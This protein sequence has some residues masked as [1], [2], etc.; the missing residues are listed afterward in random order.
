MTLLTGKHNTAYGL[1]SSSCGALFS[2]KLKI[3]DF[4]I[5]AMSRTAIFLKLRII[6]VTQY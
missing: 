4:S 3:S 6:L 2:E 1:K 5:F